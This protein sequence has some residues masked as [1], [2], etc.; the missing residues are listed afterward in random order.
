MLLLNSLE[1]QGVWVVE[2]KGTYKRDV[3]EELVSQE[4]K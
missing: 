1:L 2:Q 4:E 3:N